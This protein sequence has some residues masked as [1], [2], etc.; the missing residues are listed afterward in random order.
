MTHHYDRYLLLRENVA[1]KCVDI[2]RQL[3]KKFNEAIQSS[4]VKRMRLYADTLQQF[5]K[6]DIVEPLYCRHNWVT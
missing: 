6:V 2:E 5:Q 1:A 4:D 3:L